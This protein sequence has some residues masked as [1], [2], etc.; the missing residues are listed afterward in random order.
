MVTEQLYLK[1]II[2]GCL[3]MWLLIA[4]LKGFAEQCAL[5]LYRTSLGKEGDRV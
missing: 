2:F 1:K 3:F 4:I 5:Q